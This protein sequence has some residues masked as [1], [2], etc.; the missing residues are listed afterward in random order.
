M[1]RSRGL[2]V[3]LFL[4]LCAACGTPAQVAKQV[5]QVPILG[6]VIP[7]QPT[8]T[9]EPIVVPTGAAQLRALWVDGFHEGIKSPKQVDTLIERA[10]QGNLN[11]LFVQVRKRGDAY[12]LKGVEPEATDVAYPG[13]PNWDPLGYLI[14]KAHTANPPLEVHAWMNAFFVG[15]TSEVF[16]DNHQWEDVRSNGSDDGY[17]YLDPGVPAVRAYTEE[18]MTQVVR[19]Y[20]V[21]GIHLDLVRYPDGGDWGYNPISLALYAKAGGSQDPPKPSDPAWQQ[22][23]RDQVTTFVRELH[24]KIKAIRPW[25][26]LSGAL[27]AYGPGPKSESDWLHSRTY[28]DVYQDWATWIRQGYLDFG[29]PMNYDRD[30]SSSQNGWFRDWVS[31]EKNS[32]GAGKVVIGVGAFLNYPE[33]TMAQIRAALAQAASGDRPLGVAIYSYASTSLYGTDDFYLAPGDQG[34]LP[35]Q[36]YA[37]STDPK[38]LADRAR[39][40][41]QWFYTALSEPSSYQD[42][43]IG[44][45]A[46]SPVFLKPAPLP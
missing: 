36:P 15:Q 24:D 14:Q 34:Y 44:K 11:A 28:T 3:S 17:G 18:V 1:S 20:N 35:R 41:N 16:Q 13:H 2:L 23:R 21:D 5:K 9:P 4:V 6:A 42:P 19:R 8:P 29:V 10:H 26:K 22:W 39:L 46:T 40:F 25:V 37:P 12:F 32:L 27:I 7:V 30:S 43:A 33:D 45:V 31:W 38:Y